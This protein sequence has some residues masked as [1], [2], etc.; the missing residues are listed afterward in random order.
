MAAKRTYATGGRKQLEY[1]PDAELERA[2]AAAR[3]AAIATGP[4]LAGLNLGWVHGHF[5]PV[6]RAMVEL[7]TPLTTAVAW[8]H[9][10][11]SLPLG[12]LKALSRLFAV[13]LLVEELEWEIA[14][15]ATCGVD[16][17]RARHR[18]KSLLEAA[19]Y[20]PA[21]VEADDVRNCVEHAFYNGEAL[22][23]LLG[24]L[25]I[26]FGR[27]RASGREVREAARVALEAWGNRGGR[28][29]QGKGV[30]GNKAA[31]KR[32]DALK[33]LTRALGIEWNE[34]TERKARAA[35][36][37]AGRPEPLKARTAKRG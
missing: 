23:D 19:I 5:V 27:S 9:D 33:D 29:P 15:S 36:R 3:A 24:R 4:G 17:A 31:T 1:D 32:A 30:V 37:Q 22:G 2:C 26:R 11:F 12:D 16:D 13:R 34:K 7:G 18:A 28:A 8:F 25:R 10:E 21:G 20:K 35:R 14:F 6:A